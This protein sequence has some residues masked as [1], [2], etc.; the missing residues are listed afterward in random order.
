MLDL[1]ICTNKLLSGL[2]HVLRPQNAHLLKHAGDVGMF[3]GVVMAT[4]DP[5]TE[6]CTRLWSYDS[7]DSPSQ[8]SMIAEVP[9]QCQF[10]LW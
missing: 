8:H 4:H 10:L 6:Q 7:R 5:I 3:L 1:S 9:Q 2:N